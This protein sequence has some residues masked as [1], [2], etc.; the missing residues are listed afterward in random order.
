[1]TRK[2]PGTRTQTKRRNYLRADVACFGMLIPSVVMSVDRFQDHNGLGKICVPGPFAK[3]VN[4]DLDLRY[5]GFHCSDCICDGKPE[6]VVAMDIERA[7][8]VARYTADQCLHAGRRY[9]TDGVRNVY[10]RRS[11]I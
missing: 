1:M 7:V 3:P 11:G 6:V 4:R 2:T 5:A 9:D 8:D 10:D